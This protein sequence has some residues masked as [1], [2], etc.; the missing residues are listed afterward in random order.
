[1]RD[2]PRELLTIT[3]AGARVKVCRRTIYAWIKAGKVEYVRTPSG[4]IRIYAD[5]LTI[6]QPNRTDDPPFT[7]PRRRKVSEKS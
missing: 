2:Q 1:M 7:F 6:D 5:S 3:E 4:S